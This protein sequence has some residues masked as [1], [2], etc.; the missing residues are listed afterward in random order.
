MADDLDDERTALAALAIGRL[1][2][3]ERARVQALVERD[4]VLARELAELRATAEL[5]SLADPDRVDR[6][7]I[8]LP[9]GLRDRVLA[10]VSR[11]RAARTR[12]VWI[13]LAASVIAVGAG[14]GVLLRTTLGGSGVDERRLFDAVPAG[15]EAS[16]TLTGESTGT[17]IEVTVE[18]LDDGHTYVVWLTDRA[19]TR[20]IAG[21]F[22]A[23]PGTEHL[24]FTAAVARDDAARL[25]ITDE[26]NNVVLDKQ[27]SP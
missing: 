8:R 3:A 7:A 5:A 20:T 2:E 16:Y 25:W 6:G 10:A 24:T 19:D 1:D 11:D 23:V 22:R 4:P 21:S 26:S 12:R 9:D 27:L 13:A 14:A 18:G 17:R 15:V